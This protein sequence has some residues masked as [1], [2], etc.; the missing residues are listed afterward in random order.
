MLHKQP[1][2][3]DCCVTYLMENDLLDA[4]LDQQLGTLIAGEQGH[5]DALQHTQASVKQGSAGVVSSTVFR[6]SSA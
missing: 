2:T 1:I 6:I 3:L 4:S 5:V